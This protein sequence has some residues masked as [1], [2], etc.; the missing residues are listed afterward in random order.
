VSD[1][2]DYAVQFVAK[3]KVELLEF[4]RDERPLGATEVAGRPLQSAVLHVS[5]AA[6]TYIG[7]VSSY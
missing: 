1:A 4:P 2:N 3:E 6:V 7:F 5:P